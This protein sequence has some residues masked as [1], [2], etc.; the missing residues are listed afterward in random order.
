MRTWLVGVMVLWAGMTGAVAENVP[1]SLVSLLHEMTDRDA[2]ARWPDPAFTGRLASSYDRKSTELGKPS[3]FENTD[4][5]Q[6]I[7][8]EE[9]AGRHEWVMMEADGPGA[10]VRVWTAGKPA[11]GTVRFYLDGNPEPV[12]AG[13]MQDMLGG[14]GLFT[15]LWD[16]GVDT[17]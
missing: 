11:T 2:V 12:I 9:T 1:V 15:V 7:R 17:L 10:V 14:R 16:N 3:W 8:H 4:W 6:F 5:S 13:Q